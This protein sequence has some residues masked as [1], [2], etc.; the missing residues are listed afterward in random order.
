EHFAPASAIAEA[1]SSV[2]IL[3]VPAAAL[4]RRVRASL[5]IR[6]ANQHRLAPVGAQT[7]E[8][9]TRTCAELLEQVDVRDSLIASAIALGIGV[10]TVDQPTADAGTDSDEPLL[11]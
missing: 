8:W 1:L 7:I 2:L 11:S 3:R 5:V 9:A 6:I 4:E 10:D